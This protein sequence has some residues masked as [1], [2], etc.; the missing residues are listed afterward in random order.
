MAFTIVQ[1]AIIWL[2]SLTVCCQAEPELY[3]SNKTIPVLG[4]L[5][6]ASRSGLQAGTLD[7]NYSVPTPGATVFNTGHAIGPGTLEGRDL[8]VLDTR[9]TCPPTHPGTS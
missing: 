6:R 2:M 8:D 1:I 7:S 9:Q 5:R 3:W 4:K